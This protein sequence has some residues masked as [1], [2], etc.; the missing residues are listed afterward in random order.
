MNFTK[1]NTY[2]DSYERAFEA[3][4]NQLFERWVRRNQTSQ[5]KYFSTI[6]GDGGDGGVEAYAVLKNG[7]VLGVQSKWFPFNIENSQVGQIRKSINTAIKVRPNLKQYI[8]CLPKD[9]SSLT[10]R[11]KNKENTEKARLNKLKDEI[12]KKYTALELIFWDEHQLRIQ[13]QKSGNEG[14]HRFWFEKAEISM[15]S[16]K[17]KFELEKTGWLNDR[18]VPKIY[19]LRDLVDHQ[20][21][22]LL[23]ADILNKY[24]Q[25]RKKVL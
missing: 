7:E 5:L 6:R 16:L 13:L 10:A 21:F 9:L 25:I 24:D 20:N 19:T 17:R 18:Y 12:N 15:E 3:L 2:N 1:I 23:G 22:R 14:I 11:N 4:C 8:I